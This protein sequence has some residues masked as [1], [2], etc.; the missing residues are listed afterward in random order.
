[1]NNDDFIYYRVRDNENLYNIVSKYDSTINS[2]ITANPR[3]NP[4]LLQK[5]EVIVIPKNKE[6]VQIEPYDYLKLK[7]NIESLKVLYPFIKVDII[8]KSVCNNNIY[9]ITIG[10]GN[11]TVIYNGAH[12]ANEWITS[13]LLMKWL[14]NTCM[15]YSLNGSIKGYEIH[16]LLNK[17]KIII[18]PM[19]NPDGVNLVVNGLESIDKNY[20][21]KL[22]LWNNKK[23]DFSKWKANING[24]DLNRNYN[25]GWYLHKKIEKEI[26]ATIPTTS[27]YGGSRPESEP[28]V[29]SMV[30]I[31]NRYN[32][33]LTLSYHSQG[34]T[35]F[36]NY[37]E[38]EPSISYNIACKLCEVSNYDLDEALLHQSHAGYKDWFIGEFRRPGF[39]IEIGKGE[40]PLPLSQFDVIYEN[41]EELLLLA[42]IIS[43]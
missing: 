38:M 43:N 27:L 36:W 18:V 11:E 16:K 12:H 37:R 40:N 41:N 30:S 5:G 19:V 35:I 8:G 32:P 7:K 20:R 17:V 10:N 22:Y 6:I 3:I 21:K 31:T 24:V 14:E 28:E 29:K 2:V 13:L 42:S 39:T 9:G 1:M 34:R 25:A 33:K 23:T 15:V 4:F 26:G